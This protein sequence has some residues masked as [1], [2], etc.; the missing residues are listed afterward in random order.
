MSKQWQWHFYSKPKVTLFFHYT[1]WLLF[2]VMDTQSMSACLVTYGMWLKRLCYAAL[3]LALNCDSFYSNEI[4]A[5]RHHSHNVSEKHFFMLTF[6]KMKKLSGWPV[7]WLPLTLCFS[8]YVFVL[9]LC[10]C[11]YLTLRLAKWKVLW[12]TFTFRIESGSEKGISNSSSLVQVV[13]VSKSTWPAQWFCS[14]KRYF[15]PITQAIVVVHSYETR[16]RGRG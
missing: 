4:S 15:G 11:V 14:G 5:A 16:L 2:K 6:S 7:F 1:S 8:L 3:G 9:F 10:Y 13:W 12:N